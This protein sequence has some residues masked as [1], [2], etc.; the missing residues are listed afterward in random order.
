MKNLSKKIAVALSVLAVLLVGCS[1]DVGGS[2]NN[3]ALLASLLNNNSNSS[4]SGQIKQ[5]KIY[6]TNDEELI[7]FGES[8]TILPQAIDASKLTFYFWGTDQINAASNT[9][10]NKPQIKTFNDSGDGV[11]GTVDVDLSIS[12]YKLK[13]AACSNDDLPAEDP[14]AATYIKNIM[15]KALLY[16]VADVDL[17]YN[18]D[19]KFYLNPNNIEGV[20]SVDIILRTLNQWKDEGYSVTVR[21]E[22]KATGT[23][24]S[25]KNIPTPESS[26]QEWHTQTGDKSTWDAPAANTSGDVNGGI[27]TTTG[28]EYKVTKIPA[29]SYNLV[30]DFYNGTKHYYYTDTLMILTNQVANKTNNG[31]YD[32][33]G[34]VYYVE[35]PQVIN[36]EPAAPE[37]LRVGYVDADD[38]D[39]GY[40]IATFEWD[41]VSTNEEYF[42]LQLLRLDECNNGATTPATNKTGF[43]DATKTALIALRD[44]ADVNETPT[45][46]VPAGWKALAAHTKAEKIQLRETVFQ[47]TKSK[48]AAGSLNKGST[49]LS[50]YLPLGSAYVARLTAINEASKSVDGGFDGTNDTSMQ[51]WIYTNADALT[52]VTPRP[53]TLNV[54]TANLPGEIVSP[55]S[56]TGTGTTAPL[57]VNRYRMLYNLNGGSFNDVN[58]VG[59]P[60]SFGTPVH[61]SDLIA[62]GLERT[63]YRYITKYSNISEDG[64]AFVDPLIWEYKTTAPNKYV[65]L[66]NGNLTFKTW[67]KDSIDGPVYAKYNWDPDYDADGLTSPGDDAKV[68][69][70]TGYGILNIGCNLVGGAQASG[71]YSTTHSSDGKL[72]TNKEFIVTYPE[73]QPLGTSTYPQFGNITLVAN[74]GAA[75]ADVQIDNKYNYNLYS[76]NIRAFKI[77]GTVNATYKYT[78]SP[79]AA[80]GV[81]TDTTG[82][83]GSNGLTS[84]LDCTGLTGSPLAA[85][86]HYDNGEVTQ[87]TNKVSD[88]WTQLSFVLVENTTTPA[89]DVYNRASLVVSRDDGM[90]GVSHVEGVKTT[91]YVTAATKG[92]AENKVTKQTTAADAGHAGSDPLLGN[93]ADAGFHN[94]YYFVINTSSLL[95]GKYTATINGFTDEN[96]KT[97]YSKNVHFE[98][99]EP[100]YPDTAYTVQAKESTAAGTYYVKSGSTYVPSNYD[101]PKK[102]F[103]ADGQLVYTRAGQPLY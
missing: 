70:N 57:C 103:D 23:V 92:S 25:N 94:A 76:Q 69:V 88:Y 80:T 53:V 9:S 3:K 29:G 50:L 73:A 52:N 2:M 32:S 11:T 20:G 66:Y 78:S 8:R 19:V 46:D 61:D 101:T 84:V 86:T 22:D 95:P 48:Y 37:N 45:K 33:V 36:K 16:A 60:S 31:T 26:S 64:S 96:E 43:D 71:P 41:R 91:F 56:W 62:Q 15:A 14:A 100:V 4:T 65:T 67:L 40:Y 89:K 24:I 28:V 79:D 99:T 13:L 98:I 38:N 21:I 72:Y 93:P 18:Q 39:D 49:S 51:K 10:I 68:F 54:T 90:Q 85:V 6:A 81:N 30:V 82:D 17:R 1:N 55:V 34:K 102:Q 5:L 58:A 74:F 12:S 35:I 75:D 77:R 27:A 42:L 83:G 44:T 87:G 63:Y 7:N 97:P 59:F 47:E